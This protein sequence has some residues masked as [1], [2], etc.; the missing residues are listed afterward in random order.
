MQKQGNL[1][2]ADDIRTMKEVLKDEAE[3]PGLPLGVA[4]APANRSDKTRASK[5]EF[6][7]LASK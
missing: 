2:K 7:I 1:A 6:P 5:Y 4:Q 3:V